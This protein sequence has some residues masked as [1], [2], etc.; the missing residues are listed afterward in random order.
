MSLPALRHARGA[1]SR[2]PESRFQVLALTIVRAENA[3]IWRS[4]EVELSNSR[5]DVAIEVSSL[6]GGGKFD[7]LNRLLSERV[8]AQPDWLLVIDD[9]VVLPS[10][11]LDVFLTVADHFRLKIA[12]PA[13][14]MLSHASWPITR[15]RPL[16]IA[17]TTNFVEIGPVT[18]LDREAIARL[19]P[20][21]SRGMGWG[22]DFNW[23]ERARELTWDIGIVDL[24]PITHMTPAAST[25][26]Q[27]AAARSMEHQRRQRPRTN[28]TFRRWGGRGRLGPTA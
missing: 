2:R 18:A 13:H 16:S 11:F 23:A 21:P 10:E 20:F 5:H 4:A 26:S 7:H 22:L 27:A 3:A 9:D 19:T 6:Q 1:A 17:R 28:A 14:R 12:Q 8:V 15:R 24:T 25:Y